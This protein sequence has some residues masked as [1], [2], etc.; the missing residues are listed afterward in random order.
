MH[1]HNS[2]HESRSIRDQ[3]RLTWALV[4][5]VGY[6]VAEIIGGLAA[7]SLALL[8]D[9][10]HMFSDSAA[11]LLSVFAVWIARR[12]PTPRRTYGYYRAEILAAL[13]NGATLIAISGWI[14]VEAI[15]RFSA[16]PAVQGK[17]LTMIAVGG[18]IV[19][20]VGLVILGQGKSDS[21]NVRGAWLH[22]L[23]D[24]L[25]SVAAI[26][27]GILIWAVGWNWVDPVASALIGLLVIHSAWNLVTEAVA[28]LMESTPGHIDL[29]EVRNALISVSGTREVHDLHVWTITSGLDALSA[30]VII[31]EGQQ[32]HTLL[33][34][35]RRMLHLRFGIDHM[36]IQIEPLDFRECQ[37]SC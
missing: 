12:P 21:L 13:I 23:T 16:P 27:A 1:Q 31:D 10:G 37:T 36:T 34:E 15:H 33:A 22:M 18:L 26:T 5:V 6:M 29:D 17:L 4:L 32:S 8:A 3:K 25:G 14:F 20:L 24:T 11:L 35:I 19:N 7:N 9:A 2:S 28:I 30:H